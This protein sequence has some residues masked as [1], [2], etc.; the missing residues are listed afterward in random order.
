MQEI[1]IE[2]YADPINAGHAG[3]IEPADKSWI[4]YIGLDGTPRFYPHRDDTGAVQD[5]GYGPKTATPGDDL[6]A[7]VRRWLDGPPSYS[8]GSLASGSATEDNNRA[9][10]RED[11]RNRAAVLRQTLADFPGARY[12]ID[13]IEGWVRSRCGG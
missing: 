13:E 8:Q 4:V 9:R 3:Y 7:F 10:W 11:M 6:I 1:K 2:R 5:S 12:V